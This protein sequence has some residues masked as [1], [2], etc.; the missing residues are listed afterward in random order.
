MHLPHKSKGQYK[1]F[2]LQGKKAL[3]ITTS[4]FTLDTIDKKTGEITK[5]GKATGVYAS[6]FTEP[7]YTFLDAQMDVDLASIKGGQIPI[8]KLY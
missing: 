4:Q 6:E 7:Y 3:V 5:V 1:I 2:N 8:E